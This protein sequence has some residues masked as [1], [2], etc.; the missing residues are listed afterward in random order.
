M[1]MRCILFLLMVLTGGVAGAQGLLKQ[2]FHANGRLSSTL[3]SDGEAVR[4]ITYYESGR[5][6]EIGGFRHGKRDGVWK[7][8]S[9]SGAVLAK[10]RFVKG[11]RQGTWEFR[12][13]EDLLHGRSSYVAD[14]LHNA[15][16]FDREGQLIA[17]STYP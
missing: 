6:K 16:V 17:R 4:F 10:A 11:K 1:A 13:P 9:E 2:E 15:E 12:T 8:M 5:V 3:Y 14:K 7:Q